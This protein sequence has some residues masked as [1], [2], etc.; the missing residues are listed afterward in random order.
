MH[1]FLSKEDAEAESTNKHL[2]TKACLS[3]DKSFNVAWPTFLQLT[4]S[5]FLAKI[6]CDFAEGFNVWTD[7]QNIFMCCSMFALISK[8][9]N[10]S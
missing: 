2:K 5:A 10:N 6:S 8:C 9:L 3:T 7:L 4:M 1:F